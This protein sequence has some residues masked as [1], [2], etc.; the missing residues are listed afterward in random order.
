MKKLS[1]VIKK[2]DS[3]IIFLIIT[4]FYAVGN[5]IWWKINTPLIPVSISATHF[6]G[7]FKKEFLYY[8]A[9]LL[10]W[11]MKGMFFIFGKK[12]F[13]L[14]IIFVN[15]L[16]FITGLF[17]IYKL[18][19]EIKDKLAGNIAMILFALT[20]CVY[21]MS[22]YYGHQDWHIVTPMIFN[23]YCLIK[24]KLFTNRKWSIIYGISVGLGLLVKDTF[25]AYFFMPW[26][27]IVFYSLLQKFDFLKIKNILITIFLGCLI[28]GI[29]YFRYLII[30]KILTDNIQQSVPI[31]FYTTRCLT[32]GLWEELLSPPIFI[33]FIIGL[34]AFILKYKKNDIKFI[35]LIWFIFPYLSIF[36]MKHYK[37]PEYCLGFVPALIVMISVFL[38]NINKKIIKN[39]IL[40]LIL[41]IGFF[42]Y[43]CFSFFPKRIAD[44]GININEHFRTHYYNT[45]S[46]LFSLSKKDKTLDALIAFLKK[47][48][49]KSVVGISET[50]ENP[51]H[52]DEIA[53]GL[54]LNDMSYTN[55]KIFNEDILVID[56][57]EFFSKLLLN[58]IVL[59]NYTSKEELINRCVREYNT[60]TYK[61]E[62]FNKK[63]QHIINKLEQFMDFI[64]EKYY[65]VYE[66]EIEKSGDWANNIIIFKRKS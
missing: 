54:L 28:S 25:L 33:L 39:I 52:D 6:I 7:V 17:F 43:L 61:K 1:S 41:I 42:Q 56:L 65:K 34:I 44:Y 63:R 18:G 53:L 26:I 49:P 21:I 64:S 51:I 14:Q 22:R 45:D 32:T 19:E 11:I 48:Y 59:F 60:F 47:Y 24:T 15:Y 40:I 8:Y 36:F 31:N 55:I 37:S 16:F 35:I 57:E 10:V 20:P 4:V 27:Y 29:H 38:S 3:L 30:N 66:I 2:N 46:I 13:D 5:F 50:I 9:P 12:Y 23:I 58:D 62:T